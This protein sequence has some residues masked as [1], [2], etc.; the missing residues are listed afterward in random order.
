MEKKTPKFSPHPTPSCIYLVSTTIS[1][2]C[3]SSV[4]SQLLS[5]TL[6]QSDWPCHCSS[7]FSPKDCIT[8]TH[9]DLETW[10]EVSTTGLLPMAMGGHVP[11]GHWPVQ[12]LIRVIFFD[13]EHQKYVTF[14]SRFMCFW[15]V[16]VLSNQ[17][18]LLVQ[19]PV[20]WLG[21]IWSRN[22]PCMH[23]LVVVI[24]TSIT[25][26]MAPCW[27]Y[28]GCLLTCVWRFNAYAKTPW[29]CDASCL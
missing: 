20:R 29:W 2:C 26:L 28:R 13:G 8:H 6:F 27:S 1:Y 19:T 22:M 14:S 7:S 10:Y 5:C 24:S 12:G 16:A 25:Q 23:S 18:N 11:F 9:T 15:T 4:K 17:D 21:L 3:W